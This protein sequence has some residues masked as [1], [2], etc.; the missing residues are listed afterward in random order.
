MRVFF[1]LCL[2]SVTGLAVAAGPED[3]VWLMTSGSDPE[4]SDYVSIHQNGDTLLF[5]DLD[6]GT[7]GWD[8]FQGQRVGNTAILGVVASK[9]T[10]AASLQLEF[11]GGDAARVTLVSCDASGDSSCNFE[12]GAVFDL[13]KQF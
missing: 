9:F 5:I 10:A 4:F 2:L 1:L 7:W 8:A 3:G 13:V 6:P 12:G 11:L